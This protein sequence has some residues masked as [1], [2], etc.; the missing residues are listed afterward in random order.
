[1]CIYSALIRRWIEYRV[2]FFS[3]APV[4]LSDSVVN[5]LQ[6]ISLMYP[7]LFVQVEQIRQKMIHCILRN[8]E[9]FLSTLSLEKK[10]E[11]TL[12]LKNRKISKYHKI[13]E[14]LRSSRLR[15]VTET[16]WYLQWYSRIIFH[17]V[18]KASFRNTVLLNCYMH[19]YTGY[20]KSFKKL[21]ELPTMKTR[22]YHAFSWPNHKSSF[23]SFVSVI[24]SHWG[25]SCSL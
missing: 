17:E 5:K 7:R 19:M 10:R 22:I 4:A 8:S 25:L 21:A 2:I 11:E 3:Y 23:P 20:K 6:M 9:L 14:L 1:M 24:F 13:S 18:V 15:Y 16:K 12:F